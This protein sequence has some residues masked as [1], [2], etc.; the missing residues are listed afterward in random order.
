LKPL[1]EQTLSNSATSRASLTLSSIS[2][3]L[4]LSIVSRK[5][6]DLS[7]DIIPE[8]VFSHDGLTP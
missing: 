8:A 3:T 1:S 6:G 4:I 7:T 2:S 5:A